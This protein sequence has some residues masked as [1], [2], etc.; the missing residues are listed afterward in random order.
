MRPNPNATT[1]RIVHSLPCME[2]IASKLRR[3]R[4]MYRYYLCEMLKLLGH[5]SAIRCEVDFESLHEGTE[6]NISLAFVTTHY[7]QNGRQ[8]I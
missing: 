7:H 4:G 2:A 1:L 8:Q 3:C 6:G 5:G